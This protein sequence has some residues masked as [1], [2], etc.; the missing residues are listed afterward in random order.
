M[1]IPGMSVVMNQSRV[2][3]QASLSVMKMTM[4][5]A[6]EKGN[7]VTELANSAT[8]AMEQSVRPKLGNNI[9]INA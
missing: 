3:Q 8:K 9:D 7:M 5:V 4:N 1:D 2:Q 6:K